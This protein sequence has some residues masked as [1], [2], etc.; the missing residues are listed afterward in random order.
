MVQYGCSP[1]KPRG[2]QPRVDCAATDL[3]KSFWVAAKASGCSV[4]SA[5]P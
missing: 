4:M 1:L 2:N 5:M 3:M